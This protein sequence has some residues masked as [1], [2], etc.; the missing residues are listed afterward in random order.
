MENNNKPDGLAG[1]KVIEYV[2]RPKHGGRLTIPPL[3]YTIF[4]PDTQH[5]EVRTGQAHE[6]LVTPGKAA[7]AT[8]AAASTRSLALPGDITSA[9]IA[10]QWPPLA[11]ISS[12]ND[13]AAELL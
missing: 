13:A 4:N 6:V 11:T 10:M 9:L 5:Y 1:R 2:L 12:H 8:P 3:N 7:A